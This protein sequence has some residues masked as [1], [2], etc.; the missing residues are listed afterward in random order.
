MEKDNG[1]SSKT[2]NRTTTLFSDTTTGLSKWIL[3]HPC[4]LQHYSQ[5]PRYGN[6]PD[7][8]Q[9]NGL[10]KCDIYIMCIYIYSH[11]IYVSHKRTHYIYTHMYIYNGVSFTHKEE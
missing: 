3:A 5:E 8:L 6:S 9:K 1:D 2:E 11:D 4:I 7:A 10:R